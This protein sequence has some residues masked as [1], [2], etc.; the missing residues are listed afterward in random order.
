MRPKDVRFHERLSVADATVDMA[1]RR[2]VDDCLRACCCFADDSA[3]C[4]IA[5]YESIAWIVITIGKIFRVSSVS[6][7]IVVSYKNGRFVTQQIAVEIAANEATTTGD[8]NPFHKP[9]PPEREPRPS[10]C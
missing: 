5:A 3:T 2:E 8:D 4:D 10:V 7:S 6:Q 9:R 1:L